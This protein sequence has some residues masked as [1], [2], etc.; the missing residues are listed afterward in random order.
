MLFHEEL[1]LSYFGGFD[2]TERLCGQAERKSFI[3]QRRAFPKKKKNSLSQS[4]TLL[5]T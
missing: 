3:E 2:R 1:E 5:T 4:Y